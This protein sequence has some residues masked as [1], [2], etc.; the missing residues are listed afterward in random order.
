M[1]QTQKGVTSLQGHLF[2]TRF[3]LE[4]ILFNLAGAIY[5]RHVGSARF[6]VIKPIEL[7]L[8]ISVISTNAIFSLTDFKHFSFYS[9][10]LCEIG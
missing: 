5:L 2:F 8:D 10:V 1:G 9:I 4:K 6:F 7:N 3:S